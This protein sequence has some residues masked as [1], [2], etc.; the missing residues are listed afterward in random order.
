MAATAVLA[1]HKVSIL[2]GIRARSAAPP[3]VRHVP[4]PGRVT[5]ARDLS[6]AGGHCSSSRRP[7]S[8]PGGRKRVPGLTG[9]VLRQQSPRGRAARWAH[10]P[11]GR[12]SVDAQLARR[13]GFR[14]TGTRRGGPARCT[15]RPSAF[16][17]DRRRRQR[18][19]PS[20]Y[21]R[22]APHRQL[23]QAVVRR[24]DCGASHSRLAPVTTSR[25]STSRA[26]ATRG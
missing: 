10:R 23:A 20:V 21:R 12:L 9:R 6:R 22:T 2:D 14:S 18:R 19:I 11:A 25:S 15:F 13:A 26:R 16:G 1:T 5:R 7:A 4:G 8:P 24:A 17:P 3:L